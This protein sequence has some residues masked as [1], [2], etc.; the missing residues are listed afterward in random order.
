MIVVTTPLEV[1]KLLVAT[2]EGI[3]GMPGR[4]FVQTEMGPRPPEGLYATI[5][6]RD[7]QLLNQSQGYWEFP[8]KTKIRPAVQKLANPS[9]V[10]VQV[11]FW[12]AEAYHKAIELTHGLQNAQRFFD[13]WR[14]LGYAGVD[15]VQDISTAFEGRIQQRAFFNFRFYVLYGAEY[16]GDWFNTSRWNL[17]PPEH[18]G[19]DQEFKEKEIFKCPLP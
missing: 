13:L 5:W 11:S 2:I 8:S 7:T 3:M 9:L 15:P 16:P 6:F 17:R 10:T 1:E 19:Y 14:P 18:P 12:G 4:V